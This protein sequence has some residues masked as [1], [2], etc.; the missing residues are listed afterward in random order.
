M[1]TLER[2]VESV[3][4]ENLESL[5]M[6][7]SKFRG[8]IQARRFA[9]PVSGIVGDITLDQFAIV[10]NVKVKISFIRVPIYE[11][12]DGSLSTLPISSYVN[13][14]GQRRTDSSF[15]PGVGDLIVQ[16]WNEVAISNTAQDTTAELPVGGEEVS[17]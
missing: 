13:S 17:E 5:G 16:K 9:T 10:D 6:E 4:V 15:T 12:D 14:E 7:V 3:E 1:A 11:R 8:R 2:A